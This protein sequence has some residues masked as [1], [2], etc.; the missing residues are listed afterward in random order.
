ML[1]QTETA[2]VT[3]LRPQQRPFFRL[4]VNSRATLDAQVIL[5]SYPALIPGFCG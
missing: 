2:P 3:E 4:F 1:V 5:S